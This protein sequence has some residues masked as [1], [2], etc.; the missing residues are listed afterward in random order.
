M[1][2]DT[3]MLCRED[4][5]LSALPV[6]KDLGILYD[7]YKR[8][9]GAFWTVDEID[10]S[11]DKLDWDTK[12]SADDRHFFSTV[13]AFFSASDIIVNNNLGDN[14]LREFKPFIVKQLLTFQMMIENIHSVTYA[15]TIDILVPD[16]ADKLRLLDALRNFPAVKAKAAWCDRW[17]NPETATLGE[18]LVAW[19]CV[20]GIFFSGSF[21]A[22]FWLKKRNLM[23]GATFSNELISRDEGLHRDTSVALFKLLEPEFRPSAARVVE[24]VLSA[25]EFEKAFLCDA[26]PVDLIGINSR[27]MAQYIEFVADHLLSSLGFAKHFRVQN[28]FPWMDLISVEGKTNF[29]EKRVGEYAKSKI[30]MNDV[31]GSA[32]LL[33]RDDIDF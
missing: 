3:P 4:D 17:T 22:L 32:A 18:R 15:T 23:P 20:E 10:F 16:P 27:T 13:F 19:A 2:V 14:F 21:C 28:P 33:I 26:L 31:S 24:I 25:V 1:S 6:R 8:A 12:M 30:P 11:Q 9:E 7:M 29:F 5:V